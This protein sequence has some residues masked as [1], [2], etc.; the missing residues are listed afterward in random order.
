MHDSN[1]PEVSN[2]NT[3]KRIII[4]FRAGLSKLIYISRK[5]KNYRPSNIL[6]QSIP[7]NSR[8]VETQANIIDR[9]PSVRTKEIV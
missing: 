3:P 7:I 8:P 2:I 5:Q 6:I 1:I 9:T 4:N